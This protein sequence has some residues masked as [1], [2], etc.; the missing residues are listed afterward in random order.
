MAAKKFNPVKVLEIFR[1]FCTEKY[2]FGDLALKYDTYPSTIS[3]IISRKRHSSVKL[4]SD[5]ETKLLKIDRRVL[6]RSLRDSRRDF[7]II[8]EQA[9]INK[10]KRDKSN[11]EKYRKQGRCYI[12]LI[13]LGMKLA[14]ISGKIGYCQEYVRKRVRLIDT[15]YFKNRNHSK[16]TSYFIEKARAVHSDFYD[17]SK[18]GYVNSETKVCIICPTHGEFWQRPSHHYRRKG[19]SKC[20]RSRGECQI[21][22]YLT[23]NNIEFEEQKSFDSCR[24]KQ[25]LPFDF[26]I[27]DF[28]LLIEYQG[29][30]HFEPVKFFGGEQAFKL[31]VT[32]DQIKKDW[33]LDNNIQLFEIRHD[34]DIVPELDKIINKAECENVL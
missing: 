23:E 5:L 25:V 12:D 31:R 6:G 30:Q 4:P 20:R 29:Q 17:Y 13:E 22:K 3:Q 18:V 10:E 24:L 21:F 2:T 1:D 9:M 19:C 33:C 16:D 15:D 26:Y 34:Q 28:N 7:S 32:K 8:S 11:A 14:E 27:P